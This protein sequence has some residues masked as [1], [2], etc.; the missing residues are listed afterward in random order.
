V[1]DIAHALRAL[2]EAGRRF[3]LVTVV[4]LEGSALRNVGA[5]M[6]VTADGEAIGS[7]SGGCVE[8]DAYQ[9]AR[10]ALRHDEASVLTYGISD[11]DAFAVGL[12]CGGRLEALVS[13]PDLS[14]LTTAL[15]GISRS[16]P[17]ALATVV[18][19]S[20]RSGALMAVTGASAVGSLGGQA[21][22]QAVRQ[23]VGAMLEAGQTGVRHYG[24]AGERQLA[25]VRV[26][27]QTF[28]PPPRM[29][30]FGATDFA[31]AVARVGSFLGY[32]VTV[33]DARPVFATTSRF[34]EAD[35]VV[36]RWPHD[37][38]QS[39]VAQGRIDQRTAV[40]VLTHDPK[41]DVPLLEVA[42]SSAASYIGAMGSR[43]SHEDRL[44]RLRNAGVSE[45]RLRRLR[46]P[47]GLDLGGLTPEETAVSV[48]AELVQTRRGGTGLP[49][50]NVV[51]AIH[52][53]R[54]SRAHQS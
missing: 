6:A 19:G 42:L 24:A 8:A 34:P 11:D 25:D 47:I 2:C 51:G 38:L 9:Q 12:T 3:A 20:A 49:L 41:F 17:V 31:R 54:R 46:S 45:D 37:Y 26:L 14:V 32:R 52:N 16:E 44:R 35:E 30:V 22:D 21:L 1:D 33:C 43:R 5:A 48:A 15:D 39:E 50:G 18:D 28:V 53:G 36:C 10:E 4:G 13:V 40:C 27:V 7:I 23:D 29:L